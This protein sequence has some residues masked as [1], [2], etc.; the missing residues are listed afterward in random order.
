MSKS[1][2]SCYKDLGPLHRL[3]LSICPLDPEKNKKS[4]PLLANALGVTHQYVYKWIENNRV[5]V[6]HVKKLVEMSDGEKTLND[7]SDFL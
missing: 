2:V 5:P 6:K 4:I 7:F 3:L 1:T